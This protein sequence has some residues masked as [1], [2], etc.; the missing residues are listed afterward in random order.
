MPARQAA[1]AQYEGELALYPSPREWWR[2]AALPGG[3]P[4][5]FVIPAH[6]GY[7]PIIAYSGWCLPTAAGARWE[8][9]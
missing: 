7:V 3:E 6:N 1:V 4:V 9:S 8:R 2:I 5:G